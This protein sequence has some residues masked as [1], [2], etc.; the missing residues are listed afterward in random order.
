MGA[1]FV[2]RNNRWGGNP[3]LLLLH[4]FIWRQLLNEST[5][6]NWK[7]SLQLCWHA[8]HRYRRPRTTA[9]IVKKHGQSTVMT[10]ARTCLKASLD[11]LLP[12]ITR[13][14]I[15]SNPCCC[16]SSLLTDQVSWPLGENDFNLLGFFQRNP[17]HWSPLPHH[18]RRGHHHPSSL[19]LHSIKVIA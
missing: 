8:K 4:S 3:L 5:P 7:K 18:R 6:P 19:P 9:L 13:G 1:S 15:S 10:I 2:P 12:S 16:N 14:H 11:S 17:E